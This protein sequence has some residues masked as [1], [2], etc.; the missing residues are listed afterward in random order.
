M[1]I[2]CAPESVFRKSHETQ[3]HC[4]YYCK[5]ENQSVFLPCEGKTAQLKNV[6]MNRMILLV[7]L[8]LDDKQETLTS[9]YTL[10]HHTGCRMTTSRSYIPARHARNRLDA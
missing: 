7:R 6:A 4:V 5:A 2:D 9:S 8:L 3:Y 1:S 10:R